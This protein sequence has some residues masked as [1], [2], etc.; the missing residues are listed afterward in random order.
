MS[1][2]VNYYSS[3]ESAQEYEA[4]G[5]ILSAALEFWLCYQYYEHGDFPLGTDQSLG[6]KACEKFKKLQNKLPYARLSKTNYLK[7]CQCLKALWLYKNRYDARFVS[8]EQKQK[9]KV[10]HIIGD[11]AQKLFAGRKDASFFMQAPFLKSL[12][13]KTPLEVPSLPYRIKQNL[14][15]KRTR[16]LMNNRVKDIYEA[17]FTYNDIFAAVDI[18]E[19][20]DERVVAFEVKSSF[21]VRD[22]YIQDSALQ[23]YVISHN[24][25]LDDFFLVYPDEEYIESQGLKIEALTVYNCDVE[26]LFKKKS[27]LDAVKSLQPSVEQHLK[28][29]KSV[30]ASGNMPSAPV[31]DHCSYPYECEFLRYCKNSLDW[32][33]T[34][35]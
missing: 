14:W 5:D 8:E 32:E 4:Q 1:N 7:G 16:T 22:V 30:L 18:L 10:G 26:K 21:D 29:I 13:A 31:D 34:I 12:Q 33:F 3:F 6:F 19:F 23:Y 9:F 2:I 20:N 28:E 15:L 35:Y 25:H 17:A 27:I 24:V 11:L